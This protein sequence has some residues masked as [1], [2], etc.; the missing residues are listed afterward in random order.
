MSNAMNM[1]HR[2]RA[3]SQEV[4]LLV[5]LLVVVVVVVVRLEVEE[6]VGKEGL[7]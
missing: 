7:R 1:V 2:V 5:M 6:V 4:V 3:L